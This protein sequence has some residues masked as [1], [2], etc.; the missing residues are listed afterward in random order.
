MTGISL[1]EHGI[2]V[3]DIVIRDAVI[4]VRA[5]VF[6]F[7]HGNA[8]G[9]HGAVPVR[10]EVTNEMDSV[11]CLIVLVRQL[12]I[13]ADHLD[14]LAVLAKIIRFHHAVP[15]VVSIQQGSIAPA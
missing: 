2:L 15:F 3:Q 9:E 13:P 10:A 5:A 14:E 12:G 8:A 7:F 6:P 1:I 4:E 11:R